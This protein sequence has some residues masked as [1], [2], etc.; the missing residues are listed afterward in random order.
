[1]Y[2]DKEILVVEDEVLNT[3][4]IISGLKKY[5]YTRFT[6][7]TSARAALE[8]L[9]TEH[10]DVALLD[11]T[12]ERIY[13]GIYLAREIDRLYK[14]PIVFISGRADA[15]MV[16]RI[17]K[18]NLFGVLFKPFKIQALQLMV[19][20][21]LTNSTLIKR[22]QETADQIQEQV[23]R[24]N[25]F[26]DISKMATE[27]KTVQGVL[28]KALE[29][30][31]RSFKNS[32][33]ITLRITY[34][35]QVYQS[36]NFKKTRWVLS[37]SFSH[38]KDSLVEMY[39]DIPDYTGVFPFD[40]ED[41]ET[42]NSVIKELSAIL[43]KS[44]ADQQLT[45][46]LQ[47]QKFINAILQDILGTSK[48]SIPDF[49][50]KFIQRMTSVFRLSTVHILTF[51]I[52]EGKIRRYSFK[53]AG[54]NPCVFSPAIVKKLYECLR[55]SDPS[56]VQFSSSMKTS[57]CSHYAE[58]LAE[59][60]DLRSFFIL[61]IRARASLLAAILVDSGSIPPGS[62]P[63]SDTETL[64]KFF[65][66][67]IHRILREKKLNMYHEAIEQNPAS[68]V[69]TDTEGNITFVNPAFL[70]ITGYRN[71]EVIGQNPRVLKSGEQPKEFYK[72]LWNTIL[73]GKVWRGQFHNKK[74]DGTLYWESASIS[75][76]SEAD[77]TIT[78]FIAVKE[79]ITSQVEA[80]EE[81]K[82][83]NTQ[84]KETQ[85]SLVMEEKLASI[86][87][88][89]AGVAHEINN[90]IGFVSSNFRTIKRYYEKYSI[91]INELKNL[92]SPTMEQ[93]NS[94][95]EKNKLDTIQEDMNDL[96]SESEEGFERVINI[97]N[98]LR[99][100]SRVDQVDDKVKYQINDGI[101]TTLTVAKN[102]I[103][104]KAD[105][106]TQFG[107]VPS[108]Y[109]NSSQI[110]QVILNII[111]NSVQA[112]ESENKGE[113]GTITIRT[114]SEGGFVCCKIEDNGPGIPDT[115]LPD[116]FEPF[117]TTKPVGEGTGLGLNISYDIIVNKHGGELTAGNNPSG[118]AY[119]LIK[120][121]IGKEEK[122]N[123]TN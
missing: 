59:C 61:P 96:L 43:E 62:F 16:E 70:Y 63:I 87:R 38:D 89:A 80:E 49:V 1:M 110:N 14:I 94:L 40:I 54:S 3:E 55:M 22:K 46:E 18:T 108:I 60:D 45:K 48:N 99:N 15:E 82:R 25:V 21:A 73:N 85:S 34:Q 50:R 123:G 32:E 75:P 88:L 19:K 2:K 65:V 23:R 31:P 36:I 105:V 106:E 17:E 112:I 77:G 76:I 116:I 66:L 98:S 4:F 69:I 27:E 83:I 58:L 9:Q 86:G 28:K 67:G 26:F 118:G 68:V 20:A 39:L 64:I 7:V 114:F 71:E 57:P 101:A 115:V 122:V 11:I 56:I 102:Q 104:Y 29:I 120:L 35:K 84:L 92:E 107:D 100:F 81:L 33:K 44:E 6:S 52:G 37:S 53:S 117:F 51:Y 109:C 5:G 111:I 119:F 42:F 95:M 72:E 113:R 79:D 30:I 8:K 24:L 91:F 13:S 78:G 12:L 121:P 47:S 90:P 103:K 10:Y 97:V 41:I 93:I 74:K